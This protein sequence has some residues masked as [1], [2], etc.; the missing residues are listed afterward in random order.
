MARESLDEKALRGL[1]HALGTMESLDALDL[2]YDDSSLPPIDSVV[3][4]EHVRQPMPSG[5]DVAWEVAC[6]PSP[7]RPG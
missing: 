2:P 4:L 6:M 5:G 1:A 3:H 7:R